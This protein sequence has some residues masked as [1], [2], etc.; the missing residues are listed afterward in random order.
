MSQDHGPAE[1]SGVFLIAPD[2]AILL[3]QRDDDVPPAG[4]GRWAIPGGGRE[5]DESPRDT[6]LREFEEETGIR[7][8]HLRFY[9]TVTREALPGLIPRALHLFFADDA[10]DR[11]RIAVNEGLDFRYWRPAEIPALP[12]NPVTRTLV[13]GFLAHDK[14]LGTVAFKAPRRAGVCVLELDRW[15]RVLLQLRDDDLPPERFPGHWSVP[16]GLIHPG[17]SPDLAALREFEEETGHLLDDLRFY[18]SFRAAD[19]LPTALVDLQHVYYCDADIDEAHIQVNEGQ[20]FRYF[21]PDDLD[22]L[23]VPPH[24]TTILTHFFSSPAYRALFH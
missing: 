12:M 20:A 2:G 5:G 23:R 1:G 21:A 11:A 16:G 6:A 14:Y 13:D 4:I 24:T 10:V 22:S 19:E 9:A 17:E 3:Q 8:D 18:R 15:G 7:L